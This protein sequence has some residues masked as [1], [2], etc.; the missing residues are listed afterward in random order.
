MR[1]EPNEYQ[2]ALR[3]RN[4]DRNALAELVERTRLRLFALAYADLRHFEEA[5]DAVASALVH[6][7]L[8]VQE[9]R[10]PERM[11]AWMQSIVRNEVRRRKRSTHSAALTTDQADPRSEAH[12]WILRLDIERALRRMPSQQAHAMRRFYL[13]GLSIRDI[14]AK[15]GCSEGTV[16]MW[17]LRGRRH[18]ATQMEGY[19]P[20]TSAQTTHSQLAAILHTDL[21]PTFVRMVT[22]TLRAGGYTPKV[23]KPG[24]L[25]GMIPALKT[26]Q[27]LVLDEQIGGLSAFA[28][29]HH[30]KAHSETSQISVCVLCTDPSDFLVAAYFQAGV[31]RL[32]NKRDTQSLKNPITSPTQSPTKGIPMDP[33]F[34]PAVAA[35]QT[36]DLERFRTLLREDPS[37]ATA[38]SSKSHPNLLQCVVLDG[39][40]VPHSVE[41]AQL[42]IAAG[43]EVDG[44]LIAAA[45]MDNVEVIPVLLNAGAA[46]NGDGTWSPIEDALAFG[47]HRAIRLLLERGATIHNLRIA[48]GVGRADLIDGFFHPDGSLKPEAGQLAWPFGDPAEGWSQ[49]PQDILDNAFVYACRS[50]DIETV[51][52]LLAHGARINALPPGFDYAGTGLHYAAM[53][54]NRPMVEYLLA[55]GADPC[56]KSRKVRATIHHTDSTAA[57]WAEHGGHPEIKELLDRAERGA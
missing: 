18:L 23:I 27:L 35:I 17:L 26:Y 15:S 55:H 7:C 32:V 30:I 16:K 21:Q 22:K 13:E 51:A 42:L 36:G 41:M 40:E 24:D 49:D 50:G 14:A 33:K 20:M 8:H 1:P 56:V 2:L 29:L 38:R 6:I 53:D 10:Q 5:Q 4:G 19:L 39:Y 37:L 31:N 25:S 48:A 11:T 52:R 43:A 9:L 46:I 54:G 47:A 28:F 34:Q 12:L 44:P 57:G 3:A 45:G